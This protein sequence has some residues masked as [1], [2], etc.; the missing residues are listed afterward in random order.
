MAL[1]LFFT[2]SITAPVEVSSWLSLQV[3][4]VPVMDSNPSRVPELASRPMQAISPAAPP[5]S[6]QLVISPVKILA[7]WSTVRSATWLS[8]L[9]ITAM[10]SRAMVVPFRPEEV[11]SSF[12]AREDRPMSAVPLT[13]ASMPAPEPVAS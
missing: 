1:G 4:S 6:L 5:T 11:S 2:A 10:P 7:I 9:T 3:S 13:T 8:A 12:S